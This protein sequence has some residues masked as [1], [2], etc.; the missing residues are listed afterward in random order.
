MY[1]ES[2]T[3]ENRILLKQRKGGSIL[4]VMVTTWQAIENTL[5]DLSYLISDLICE[6]CRVQDNE[7]QCTLSTNVTNSNLCLQH[8]KYLKAKRLVDDF[9]N[10]LA[11]ETV[12]NF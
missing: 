7:G 1:F 9:R 6:K 11:I 12:E 4:A 5:D 8:D 10:K 3:R 2:R